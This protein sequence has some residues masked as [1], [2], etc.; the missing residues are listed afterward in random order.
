MKKTTILVVLLTSLFLASCDADLKSKNS[1]DLI[2]SKS[3]VS[4]NGTWETIS[5]NIGSCPVL[6]SY[7]GTPYVFV[8][9]ENAK[10]SVKSFINDEWQLVGQDGFSNHEISCHQ[11]KIDVDASGIIFAAYLK[12]VDPANGIRSAVVQKYENGSW[13]QVG[14]DISYVQGFFRFNLSASGVPFIT[15]AEKNTSKGYMIKFANGTW[16]KIGYWSFSVGAATI[17]QAAVVGETPYVYFNDLESPGFC[18][19]PPMF[20]KCIIPP[21]SV[22]KIKKFQNGYWQTAVTTLPDSYYNVTFAVDNNDL[23]SID[24]ICNGEDLTVRK[25]VGSQLDPVGG[26]QSIDA[27]KYAFTVKDGI[28]YVAY[29]DGNTLKVTKYENGM[30]REIIGSTPI[31]F[32]SIRYIHGISVS[33]NSIFVAFN[34]IEDFN[35][36]VLQY[37]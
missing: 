1:K 18:Y 26:V 32:D 36:K 11:M 7:N 22:D 13:T 16:S 21:R 20:Q 29:W 15:Y 27:G 10:A 34:Q 4:E 35:V 3:R 33:G 25:L 5:E 12:E 37:K 2:S 19:G 6:T 28:P 24:G 23:Y 17:Y 9:N 30:W 14:N 8:R 31:T